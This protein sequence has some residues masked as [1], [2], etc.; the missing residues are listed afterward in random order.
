MLYGL[1]NLIELTH[2]R[3]IGV[4]EG[5]VFFMGPQPLHRLGVSFDELTGR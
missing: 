4:S 5:Y 2:R 1:S 3:A